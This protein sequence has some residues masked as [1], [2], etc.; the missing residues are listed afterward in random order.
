MVFLMTN[1][2]GVQIVSIHISSWRIL[3]IYK[4]S[5]SSD[6]YHKSYLDSRKRYAETT[7]SPYNNKIEYVLNNGN[8]SKGSH[9]VQKYV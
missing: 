2:N 1:S 7:L 5:I 6:K 9:K 8:L 3:T 4:I